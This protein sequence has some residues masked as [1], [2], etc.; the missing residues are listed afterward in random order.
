MNGF[1][2]IRGC[3]DKCAAWLLELKSENNMLAYEAIINHFFTKKK[4]ERNPLDTA[5][6]DLH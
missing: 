6:L 5:E 4:S 3:A 2:L 1:L